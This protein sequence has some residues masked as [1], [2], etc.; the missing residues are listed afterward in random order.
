VVALSACELDEVLDHVSDAR[1]DARAIA[2]PVFEAAAL[3][4]RGLACVTRA[5]GVDGAAAVAKASIALERL[6][7]EQLATRLPALWMHGR[8]RYARGEF[9]RSLRDFEHGSSIAAD[10]PAA[11]DYQT[12]VP[13]LGGHA[14]RSP[15]QSFVPCVAPQR[16]SPAVNLPG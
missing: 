8:S 7:A 9:E 5:D 3:S 14:K 4:L 6:S 10:G 15:G 1:D 13:L 12:V 2:D 16:S 11:P